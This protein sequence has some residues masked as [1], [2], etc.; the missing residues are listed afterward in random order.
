M[1]VYVTMAR[2]WTV[3]NVSYSYRCQRLL[4]FVSPLDL[5]FPEYSSQNE[6]VFCNSFRAVHYSRLKH[7]LLGLI[8]RFYYRTLLCDKV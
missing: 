5:G 1:K 7:S 8:R 3:F 4:I 6:P 2:S